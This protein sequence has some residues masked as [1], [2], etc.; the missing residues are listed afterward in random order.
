MTPPARQKRYLSQAA[1]LLLVLVLVATSAKLWAET[2]QA[3]YS[4]LVWNTPR[5][6]VFEAETG[7]EAFYADRDLHRF[8]NVSFGQLGFSSPSLKTLREK[9][10]SSFQDNPPNSQL[11][12]EIRVV[13]GH[14]WQVVTLLFPSLDNGVPLKTR[15]LF[16]TFGKQA[17]QLDW[18]HRQDDSEA[19]QMFESLF[20]S[21]SFDRRFREYLR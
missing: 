6:L 7:T 1:R 18:T 8:L 17:F 11:S 2:R 16:A 14:Q 13:N 19:D 9:H 21:L 20:Q 15:S 10:V 12:R 3:H 4:S 5:G